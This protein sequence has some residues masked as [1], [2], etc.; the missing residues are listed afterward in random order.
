MKSLLDKGAD[1]NAN[2][3]NGFSIDVGS[4]RGHAAVVTALLD[5]SADVDI[6]ENGKHH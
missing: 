1:V 2:D 4:L 3:H 5:M 6:A